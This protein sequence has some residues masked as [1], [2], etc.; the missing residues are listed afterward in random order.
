MSSALLRA[1]DSKKKTSDLV[2]MIE[3]G[4]KD[5]KEENEKMPKNKKEIENPYEIMNIVVKILDFN[6]QNQEE[7]G[8]K[9]LAPDQVLSRLPISLAQLK[10]GNDSEKP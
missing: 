1:V 8:L 3:S 2:N 4:L 7:Q 6:N 10:A 9:I 5:L